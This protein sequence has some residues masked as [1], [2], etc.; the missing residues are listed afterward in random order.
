MKVIN[1]IREI[2]QKRDNTS[3]NGGRF[4]NYTPNRKC[5]REEQI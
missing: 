2:R 4:T 1:H 3:K 5:D